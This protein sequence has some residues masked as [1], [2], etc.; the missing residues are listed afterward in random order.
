MVV[1]TNAGGAMEATAIGP[2]HPDALPKTQTFDMGAHGNDF[3][4][5][6][7]TGY[8]RIG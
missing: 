4:D 2:T 8:Q 5:G 3:A 6:F 7:M 1:S